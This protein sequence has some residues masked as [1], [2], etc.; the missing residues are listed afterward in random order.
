MKIAARRRSVSPASS[1]GDETVAMKGLA[2][3]FRLDANNRSARVARQSFSPLT[4][5]AWHGGTYS[6]TAR[7]RA[8][9]QS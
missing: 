8:N 4:K 1:R 6:T 3:K 7:D 2:K 5:R 9:I